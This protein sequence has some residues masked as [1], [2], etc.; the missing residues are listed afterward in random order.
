M[1]EFREFG[2]FPEGPQGVLGSLKKGGKKGG[3]MGLWDQ[4]MG[5]ELELISIQGELPKIPEGSQG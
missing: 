3:K 5:R 1:R 4:G 2:A